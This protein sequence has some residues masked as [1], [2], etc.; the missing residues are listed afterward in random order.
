MSMLAALVLFVA[1]DIDAEQRAG[2]DAGYAELHKSN[3]TVAITYFDKA[4]A[5]Y[6]AAHRDETRT[7]FCGMSGPQTIAS[8]AAA[9]AAHDKSGKSNGAVA[10]GRGYCEALY[11]K[12]YALIDLDRVAEARTYYE[13]VIT[14]APMHS[15]FLAE[16]GQTY[17]MEKDWAKMFDYCSRAAGV[18]EL[19]TPDAVKAEKGLAWRCMGFAKIELGEWD[20]AEKLFRDCVKLDPKDAK[21]RNELQY[22][23]EKRPKKS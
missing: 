16:M 19:A 12:G 8:L 2:I 3:P 11:G 18:A 21:A 17:R 1:Q 14:L 6:E 22:I 7:I 9:A 15:H 13:R 4:I 20:A 10:V 23:A 5:A